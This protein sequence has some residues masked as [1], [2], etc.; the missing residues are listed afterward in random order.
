[1]SHF[2]CPPSRITKKYANNFKAV[3]D[4]REGC[5]AHKQKFTV[6]LSAGDVRWA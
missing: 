4:T 3:R 2:T 5:V 1:V 6:S